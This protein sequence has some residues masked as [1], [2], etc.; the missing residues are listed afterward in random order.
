MRFFGGEKTA[1]LIDGPNLAQAA[2]VIGMEMDWGRL[3]LFFEDNAHLVGSIYFTPLLTDAEGFQPMRGLVDWLDFNGWQT[4][5]PEGPAH[6]DLAV[7]AMELANNVGHLIIG[8][9]NDTF[10]P[11]VEALQRRGRRVTV[12]STT[13]NGF[14]ADNLR[15][16]AGNFLDLQAMRDFVVRTP[17]KEAVSA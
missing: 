3:Q 14:C 12:L 16:V 17:R 11:L 7:A 9:G 15:R 8:T 4:V 6:V 5:T 13:K 10:T 1:L 2:K